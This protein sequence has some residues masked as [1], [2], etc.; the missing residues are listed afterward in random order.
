[1]LSVSQENNYWIRH[2]QSLRD[3]G[4]YH[5][6][7]HCHM[8][9]EDEPVFCFKVQYATVFYYDFSIN[10]C[11]V[12]QAR[13]VSF[14][15]RTECLW[16]DLSAVCGLQLEHQSV[17]RRWPPASPSSADRWLTASTCTAS[18]AQSHSRGHLHVKGQGRVQW[19]R[20]VSLKVRFD[21]DEC[22]RAYLF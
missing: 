3:T 8:S 21:F 12:R 18:A 5:T 2:W 22:G 1:M 10:L 6:L 11:P 14:V 17:P 20:F 7:Q 19:K 4:D 9:E 16:P 13:H 15:D